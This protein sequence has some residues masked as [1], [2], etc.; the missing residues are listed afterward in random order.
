MSIIV[1]THSTQEEEA[2]L[3][4]LDSM[5]FDYVKD[6]ESVI[7]TDEQKREILE[8]DREYEA[9]ETETYSLDEVIAYFNIKEK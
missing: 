4:F 6:D 3:T 2:L 5:K 7:L 1:N 9:G 8:R